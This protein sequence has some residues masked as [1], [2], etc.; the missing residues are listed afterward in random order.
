LYKVHLTGG[1]G[2]KKE[3]A[4]LGKSPESIFGRLCFREGERAK[5]VVNRQISKRKLILLRR[6]ITEREAKKNEFKGNE[7]PTRQKENQRLVDPDC[8]Y[9][10]FRRSNSKK[11]RTA[12]GRAQT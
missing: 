5:T 4:I 6:K 10:T 9:E 8:P 3:R 7:K 11:V 1:R 2:V 12:G